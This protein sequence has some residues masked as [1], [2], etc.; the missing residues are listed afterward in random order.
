MASESSAGRSHTASA[1]SHGLGGLQAGFAKN[2]KKVVGAVLPNDIT[3]HVCR[4]G[5]ISV[6][7]DL[8]LAESTV[9]PLVGHK[10]YTTTSLYT[11]VADE[12]QLKAVDRIA[13]RIV[14]LMGDRS[15][16]EAQVVAIR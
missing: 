5:F 13:D 14:E 7:A 2:W 3:P 8:Q 15:P 12:V 11:H 6:G 16:V 9:G 4:H 10:G 1:F